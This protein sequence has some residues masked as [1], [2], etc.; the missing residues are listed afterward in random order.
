MDLQ[1]TAQDQLRG[2]Q[3]A[4]K[5]VEEALDRAKEKRPK[6]CTAK[7]QK[8][9]AFREGYWNGLLVAHCFHVW[10]QFPLQEQNAKDI[11]E[12]LKD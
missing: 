10:G 6:R 7:M 5:R 4:A 1:G 3:A 8:S 9:A 12:T 11:A 2:Y